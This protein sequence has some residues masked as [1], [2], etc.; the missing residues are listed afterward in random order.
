MTWRRQS[1]DWNWRSPLSL[2]INPHLAVISSNLGN[3]LS[4]R[5][6]RTE[7]KKDLEAAILR[8][9]LAVSTTPENHSDQA[10]R[11][12]GLGLRLWDQ[13]NQTGEIDDLEA[14][15]SRIEMA[16]SSTSRDHPNWLTR[17]SNLGSVLSDRYDRTRNMDDFEAAISTTE[18]ALSA[19]PGDSP[20]RA[21]MLVN[22]GAML[23]D[24]YSQTRNLD[25]LQASLRS[26]IS[27][28][29]LSNAIPLGRM[30]ATRRAIRIIISVEKWDQACS[31]AQGAMNFSL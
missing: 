31:L 1:Q 24:R 22:L 28:F 13:Y 17:L 27:A 8:A 18:L 4:V 6:K 30:K 21:P 26:Y 16:V 3:I 5:Y 7:N 19:L 14:A 2:K 20:N 12:N 15:I 9:K 23:S 29:D 25:D 10:E 11:L